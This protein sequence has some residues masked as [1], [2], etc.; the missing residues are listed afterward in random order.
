M[1]E[2]KEHQKTEGREIIAS[3]KETY[4][5]SLIYT[6]VVLIL[7]L[8]ASIAFTSF[9]RLPF[10]ETFIVLAT[11]FS[12]AGT[13]TILITEYQEKLYIKLFGDNK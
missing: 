11:G 1:A 5:L 9:L 4:I 7:L 10:I 2:A 12:I 13:C 6:T 3:E 8:I